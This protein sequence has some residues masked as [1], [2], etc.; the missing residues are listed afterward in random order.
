MNG[1]PPR[2][3]LPMNVPVLG[4]TETLVDMSEMFGNI[5]PTVTFNNQEVPAAIANLMML[6]DIRDILKATYERQFGEPYEGN[7]ATP[8][9][10]AQ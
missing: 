5:F 8:T 6:Q 10:E 9:P 2:G 7:Q 1:P 3:G 4:H